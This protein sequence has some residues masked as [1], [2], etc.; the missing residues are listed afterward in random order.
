M[1]NVQTPAVEKYDR[2]KIRCVETGTV[3]DSAAAAAFAIGCSR[4]AMSNHLAG[5]HAHVR[6]KRFER[7]AEEE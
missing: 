7:V 1:D 2:H 3:Y 6:G 4:G 5:R